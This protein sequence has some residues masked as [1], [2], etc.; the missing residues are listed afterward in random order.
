V[1]ELGIQAMYS[2]AGR[3]ATPGPVPIPT[4]IG[5][6]GG[7]HGLA[8]YLAETGFTHVVDATH[9]FA[10]TMSHNAIEACRI[11]GIPLI[12][13][14]RPPWRAQEGDVW[15]NVPD[16]EHAIAGLKTD[17]L[18]IFL[19]IGRQEVARFTER[20]EHFYLLRLVDPPS[21]P[22]PLPD[23]HIVVARGPFDT[24][25]DI[26]LLE[27]HRIGLVVS[28][29]SGGSGARAKIDA[30]RALKLP[31]LMIDRPTVKGRDEVESV[32]EIL[33]WLAQDGTPLG[34]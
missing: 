14:T 2:Y 30:A 3:T 33:D 12:A 1:A 13:L 5:G 27:K 16:I 26:A 7:A 32:D 22:P 18:R 10:Q 17:P 29:N 28:K 11:I 24:D 20:P 8:E 23:H 25:T 9:P 19:A 21:T 31:V 4:R 15:V 34:V 6:F